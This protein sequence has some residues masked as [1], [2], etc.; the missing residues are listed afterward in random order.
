MDQELIKQQIK[1]LVEHGGVV[2]RTDVDEMLRRNR[3]SV[4]VAIVLQIA[5]LA[6]VLLK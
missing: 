2:P 1:Y 6:A 4:V 3:I 5:T